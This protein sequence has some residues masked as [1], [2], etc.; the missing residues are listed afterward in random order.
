MKNFAWVVVGLVACLL[1][2]AV[3]SAG[4]ADIDSAALAKAENSVDAVSDSLKSPES[5]ENGHSTAMVKALDQQ[6]TKLSADNQK[7]LAPAMRDLKQAL[8]DSTAEETRSREHTLDS[9]NAASVAIRSVKSSLRQFQV[10]RQAP[11]FLQALGRDIRTALSKISA[12]GL[13]TLVAV[14]VIIYSVFSDRGRRHVKSL[15]VS[16][17]TLKFGSLELTFKGTGREATVAQIVGLSKEVNASLLG[18]S[19][20]LQLLQR[21]EKV[22]T[23][24]KVIEQLGKACHEIKG[25]RAAIQLPDPLLSRTFFQITSY[26][27][28][29]SDLAKRAGRR[30]SIH[31]GAIGRAWTDL[32]RVSIAEDV[33]GNL[34]K[35]YNMDPQEAINRKEKSYAVIC[36]PSDGLGA[37]AVLYMDSSEAGQFP[38]PVGPFAEQI[39]ASAARTGLSDSIERIYQEMNCADPIIK[40]HED[41]DAAL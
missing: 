36:I 9:A 7:A 30:R 5:S 34:V 23:D 19:T 38:D 26:W 20:N 1:A 24:P 6:I 21:L 40:I 14:C 39:Q 10:T 32:G 22:L 25:F 28:L 11:N 15:I 8:S 41:A 37:R 17:G 16:I 13:F 18:H 29:T 27:P 4:Q 31:F 3:G 2:Y 12:L 33:E 35:N